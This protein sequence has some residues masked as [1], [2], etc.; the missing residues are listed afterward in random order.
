VKRELM[1]TINKPSQTLDFIDAIQRLGISYHFEM[2]ID[3]ILREMYR[4]PCD[5]DNG[6][7]DDHHHNDLYAISLKFR[8]LRQQGYKISC[9]MDFSSVVYFLFNIHKISFY[10]HVMF[11]V[12]MQMCSASSRTA[13]GTSMIPLSMTPE[14]F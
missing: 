1:T 12:P 6:D 13:K 2:E 14:Q 10:I 11:S 5:F 4:S 3:E 9:G 8:L 7:D